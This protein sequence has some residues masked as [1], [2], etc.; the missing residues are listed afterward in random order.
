MA[1]Q[2]SKAPFVYIVILNWNNAPDTIACLTSVSDLDYSNYQTLVID[3]GSTDGSKAKIKTNHPSVEILAL[4]NNLGYALGNNVGIHY[5][6]EAGAEY[7]LVLNNDTLVA[8]NMLTELVKV[9][10]TDAKIGMV[11][12]TM[13]CVEPPDTLFAAGSFIDWAKGETRNRGMFEP[14]TAY[15][16]LKY[17]E[18]VDYITGCAVLVR[19]E[20]IETIGG[21][22]S[23]YYLN[24]EDA[25]WG[26]RARHYDFDVWYAPQAVMW[27]KVSAS[28]GQA[29]PA[30]TYYMTRNALLFFWQN[31]PGHLRWLSLSRIIARTLQTLGAWTL[32]AEYK[33]NSFQRLRQANLLALRDFFLGHFGKMGPDVASVCYPNR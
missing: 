18:P 4:E 24:Y 26:V 12:P 21:L 27:H 19:K 31:A 16:E 11:G 1:K 30:N 7:I 28:L 29:S 23:S 33:T 5:A 10:E 13:Y 6:L 22:A 32:K 17:P 2:M 14:I 25:E 15:P 20:L 3:N 9:A 8:S